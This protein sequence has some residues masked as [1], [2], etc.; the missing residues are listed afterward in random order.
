MQKA[1]VSATAGLVPHQHEALSVAGTEFGLMRAGILP[2]LILLTL[3]G[4]GLQ[5]NSWKLLM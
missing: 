1:T 2:G 3:L 5:V 4:K